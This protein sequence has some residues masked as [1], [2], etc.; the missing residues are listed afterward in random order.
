MDMRDLDAV[1]SSWQKCI[2]PLAA[3]WHPIQET[4]PSSG[5]EFLS[6]EFIAKAGEACH[7]TRDLL[8]RL[9]R[10][11]RAV[12]EDHE[13][14]SIIWFLHNAYWPNRREIHMSQ[15]PLPVETLEEDAGLF[16]VLPLLSWIPRLQKIH[17][18]LDIPSDVI[19]DS[20]GE[21]SIRLSEA[22]SYFRTHGSP[23]IDATTMS[24][25]TMIWDGH[26]YQIG[27]FQFGIWSHSGVVRAYRNKATRSLIALSED[28]R[29]FLPNGLNDGSGGLSGLEGSWAATLEETDREVIGYPITPSG[30]AVNK[31]IRL[32]KNEWPEV[33]AKGS[34]TLDFHIPTGPPMDFE[35]CGES[36]Q[37]AIAFFRRYFPEEPFVAFECW[38]WI[39]DPVFP[40]ILPPDSN[41]V[42]FQQELYL[43]P[44]CGGSGN[45]M[46]GEVRRDDDGRIT[47]M[48]KRFSEYL[49]SGGRFNSGGF[50]LM[51]DD[52]D[53]GSQPYRRQKLP[54]PEVQVMDD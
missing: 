8:E 27:R 39:L 49:A 38:S 22:G 29:I 36:F 19:R 20:V 21:L 48:E 2:V 28:N 40:D 53:W 34:P 17:R 46:P 12:E 26:L 14:R 11:A 37:K 54:W 3:S 15:W 52:F 13:L 18:D 44:C 41:L 43:Y 23:G 47:S 4:I 35:T 10:V 32:P 51:I 16:Y 50:F 31:K 45:S 5:I 9:T 33:F 30:F 6:G 25:L 7:L 1:S 42:R 24:W